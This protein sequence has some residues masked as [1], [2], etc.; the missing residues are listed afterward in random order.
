LKRLAR[1]HAVIVAFVLATGVS[2]QLPKQR[3]EDNSDWWSLLKDDAW[4]VDLKPQNREPKSSNY[5]ILGLPLWQA[6][7]PVILHKFGRATDVERGDASTGRDQICYTSPDKKTHFIV[8]WGE[9]DTV[10]Y[11]FDRGP[12]WNGSTYC[13]L[14]ALVGPSL[15]TES[16]LRLGLSP[17]QLRS[18]L[19]RP[20][21]SETGRMLYSFGFKKRPTVKGLKELRAGNHQMSEEEFKRNFEML[22][23]SSFVDA[24]FTDRRLTYLAIWES[25]VY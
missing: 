23:V 6:D 15:S 2:A 3:I 22:D 4:A 1:L 7:I 19:G 20:S 21:I 16:G 25:E 8:E 12:D 11:V 10:V 17:Q 24:R 13:V 9:V 18:I 14:S 5:R